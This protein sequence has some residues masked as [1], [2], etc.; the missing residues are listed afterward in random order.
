MVI[1]DGK[2]QSRV[3]G[4]QVSYWSLLADKSLSIRIDETTPTKQPA[5]YSWIGKA[6]I[7][8]GLVDIVRG[9]TVFVHDLQLPQMLHSRVVRPPHYAARI[10]NLDTAVLKHVEDSGAITVRDGSFLAVAAT[11]EY[12]AIKA[13][14]RL[15]HAIQWDLGNSIPTKDVFSSLR[16]N[17]KVS[18]PVV[19]GGAPIEKPVAPLSQPPEEST[20]TLNSILEKPYLI[21]GSIGPSAA[22]A[23]Y[24]NNLLTIYTHS[25]GVYPLRGAIAEALQMP[26]DLSLIHI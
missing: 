26:L 7:P 10:V 20:I 13:A 18:L 4:A 5:D 23:V 1:D 8:K 17:P 19:E 14:A 16:T 25:Q 6:V 22:C 3:T 21:H 12:I 11:D 24:E 9:K 15:F 2:V